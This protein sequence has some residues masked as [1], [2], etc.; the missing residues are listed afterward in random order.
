MNLMVLF[1]KICNLTPPPPSTISHK[2]VCSLCVFVAKWCTGYHF[3][4]SSFKSIKTWINFSF[5][6][7]CLA[8]Y[9]AN[10]RHKEKFKLFRLKSKTKTMMK[11][12]LAT[13]FS[14]LFNVEIFPHS[15]EFFLQYVLKMFLICS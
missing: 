15:L 7:H 12:L 10:S 11:Q 4:T 6:V 3:S 5:G 13:D 1:P 2:I 9:R 8:C 14:E